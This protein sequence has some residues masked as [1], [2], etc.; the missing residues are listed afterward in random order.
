MSRA[1]IA[2]ALVALAGCAD[3][4]PVV[5]ECCVDDTLVFV[6]EGVRSWDMDAGSI[7]II[8]EDWRKLARRMQENE[9]CTE[10]AGDL[11]DYAPEQVTP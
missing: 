11:H 9:T 7:R 10:R 6:A 3:R 5:I 8:G 1:W 2:I 4:E